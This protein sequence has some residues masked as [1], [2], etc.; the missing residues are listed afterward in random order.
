MTEIG[1]VS[2][3]NIIKRHR[4]IASNF[5]FVGAKLLLLKNYWSFV[6]TNIPLHVIFLF[7]RLWK[8]SCNVIY[9]SFTPTNMKTLFMLRLLSYRSL[10]PRRRFLA[11]SIFLKIL[12]PFNFANFSKFA[13]IAKLK[14]TRKLM[15]L[16][17][18]L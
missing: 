2:Y 3:R 17:Y 1:H 4:K 11:I 16:Q 15:G 7:K 6:P 10:I 5:I 9:R 12:H 13:K 18:I 14:R 8:D